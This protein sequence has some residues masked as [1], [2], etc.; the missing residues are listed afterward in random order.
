MG[1]T[2]GFGLILV[3]LIISVVLVR[4]IAG[5]DGFECPGNAFASTIL[6]L[7]FSMAFLTFFDLFIV[8]LRVIQASL[9]LKKDIS[10]A[11]KAFERYCGLKTLDTSEQK[12]CYDVAPLKQEL[13]RLLDVG[14]DA[15]RLCKKINKINPDFCKAPKRQKQVERIST[16]RFVKGVIYE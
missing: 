2:G 8:C 12:F 3:L 1:L 9:G 5:S 13:H 16:S 10:S 4:G 6:S 7:D 15:K 14:I 11:S